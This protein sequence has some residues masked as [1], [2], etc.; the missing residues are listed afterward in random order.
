M[1]LERCNNCPRQTEEVTVISYSSGYLE[2]IGV[3]HL[4]DRTAD[5]PF[6]ELRLVKLGCGLRAREWG[7][8]ETELEALRDARVRVDDFVDQNCSLV[9]AAKEQTS[10]PGV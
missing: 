5:V 2:G 10:T 6:G 3:R 8:G 7:R 1:G 9:L 4:Y